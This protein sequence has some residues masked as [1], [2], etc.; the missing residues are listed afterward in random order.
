[1]DT[2]VDMVPKHERETMLLDLIFATI[3]TVCFYDILASIHKF[4]SQFL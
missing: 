4:Y 1:M 2:G 3:L